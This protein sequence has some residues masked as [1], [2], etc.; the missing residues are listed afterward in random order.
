MKLTWNRIV[1]DKRIPDYNNN[2]VTNLSSLRS[3]VESDYNRIIT[4]ASFRRLQDKTQVFPL[5]SSDFVRTRLT[6]SLEVASLAKLIGKQVCAEIQKKELTNEDINVHNVIETL[7][8]AALLHDIGNPPFG[9]FGESS[10]REWFKNNIIKIKYGNKTLDEIL[11]E[12]QKLDLLYYE[13]NAQALR[14]VSK[15]HRLNGKYGMHLTSG[16]LDAIIKYPVN[17]LEK[18][19]ESKKDKHHRRLIAKKIGYYESETDLFNQIKENTGTQGCRN[20]LT[21]ILEAADDLAYTFADLEDGYK[22]GMYTY[23][24]LMDVI[25]Q[26]NDEKGR[27]FLEKKLQDAKMESR[28][29]GVDYSPFKD[30]VFRWMTNKQLF[31]VSAVKDAFILNYDEIMNGTF[32][33]ELIACSSEGELIKSLKEFAYKKVYRDKSILKVEIMGNEI[34][35]FFLDQFVISVLHYDS[36]IYK[37]NDIETKYISLLSSNYLENYHE[38]TKNKSD[39]DKIYEKLLLA[40]DFVAGM[41]DG[42][43]KMIYQELKGML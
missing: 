20:P 31:C 10:I 23:D 30:A 18:E 24:E 4:S 21:F 13:G 9:H 27:E 8:C 39:E 29:E 33:N 1:S 38:S 14:I 5:D 2:R 37:V 22:K 41:T 26:S 11:N 6:H 34:L 12:Q 17:S 36:Q 28:Y 16:V 3:E 32:N 40:A 43:A 25:I 42:Y 35:K 19:L 15:L 7:N